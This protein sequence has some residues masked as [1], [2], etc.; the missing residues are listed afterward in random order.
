VATVAVRVKPGASRNR[1]GGRYEGPY[2]TAVV[3]A[4]T[5]PPVDGRATKAV[6]A[7]VAKALGV[8]RSAVTVRAGGT[9]RD[10][11]LAIADPPADLAARVATLCD[12]DT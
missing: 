1:I 8:R 11:L 7:A 9:G 12:G 10:K 2:G 5:A 6:I 4:V 3:V